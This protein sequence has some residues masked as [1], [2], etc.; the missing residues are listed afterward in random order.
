VV[1]LPVTSVVAGSAGVLAVVVADSAVVSAAGA[2]T[3]AD[4]AI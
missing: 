1:V 4:T 3:L 2:R